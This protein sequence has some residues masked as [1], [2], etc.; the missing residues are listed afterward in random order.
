MFDKSVP[1]QV[2]NVDQMVSPI[3]VQLEQVHIDLDAVPSHVYDS[4]SGYAENA[5]GGNV[6]DSANFSSVARNDLK[7][8]SKFWEGGD[9]VP[10]GSA[11]PVHSHTTIPELN[12]ADIFTVIMS[13]SKKKKLRQKKKLN[14]S[15]V[16][17]YNSRNRGGPSNLT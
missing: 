16:V 12:S 2:A 1:S 5:A 8:V 11:S 6:L 4:F 3:N 10:E 9:E 15:N 17:G 13:K 7:A 14:T